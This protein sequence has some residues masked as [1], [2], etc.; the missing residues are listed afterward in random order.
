MSV[1]NT[2]RATCIIEPAPQDYVPFGSDYG[3]QDKGDRSERVEPN[4]SA[5]VLILNI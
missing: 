2:Y 5:S 4:L 3:T 1:P